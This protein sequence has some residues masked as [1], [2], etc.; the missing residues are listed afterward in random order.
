MSSEHIQSTEPRLG[1]T[2]IFLTELAKRMKLKNFRGVYMRDELL[3]DAEKPLSQKSGIMNFDTAEKPGSHWVAWYVSDKKNNKSQLYYFDSY[4]TAV[5]DEIRRYLGGGPI[6]H[7]DFMIQ[8]VNSDICGE[9]CIAFIYLMDQNEASPQR[10]KKII[11]S[12]CS[13]KVEC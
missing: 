9:L 2:N 8:G 12:F 5:P 7:S 10:Y 13:P 4:G 11:L 6:H 3:R 1:S